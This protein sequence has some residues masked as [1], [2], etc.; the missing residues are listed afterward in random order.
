MKEFL[1]ERHQESRES[2][3]IPPA[4]LNRYLSEFIINVRKKD[5][6]E[7]EPSY[8]RGLI[9]SFDRQLRRHKYGYVIISSPEFADTREAMR[10]K[11][12]NLKS[13]GKGAKP[14]KS[15]FLS[16]QE[17]NKLYESNQ[18]G[19]ETPTS[20]INTLW[21]LNTL[22]FG[23]RGGSEEHRQICWGDIQLK[24]D[25]V[26]NLDYLERTTKTRTG[27]D[28]TNTRV[29]PPRMY[30]VPNNRDRCPVATYMFYQ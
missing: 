21:Y 16:D 10:V 20:V 27:E 13:Q 15:D 3:L 14:L 19:I 28:L 30:A 17:I 23:I 29:C 26:A 5:G 22:Y 8:L 1:T 7:Y 25:Y 12:K 11:Q 18:L 24:H 4:D 2:H 6:G 9:S